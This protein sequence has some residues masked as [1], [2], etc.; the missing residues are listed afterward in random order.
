MVSNYPFPIE[1]RGGSCVPYPFPSCV[2][3]APEPPSRSRDFNVSRGSASAKLGRSPSV[4]PVLLPPS[5]PRPSHSSLLVTHRLSIRPIKL[6]GPC[7]LTHHMCGGYASPPAQKVSS[8][9]GAGFG[10][11]PAGRTT[12]SSLDVDS[13]RQFEPA[14]SRL[15]GSR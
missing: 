1:G 7:E 5:A 13:L 10:D 12:S 2:G 9:S 15:S 3:S 6:D 4:E 11:Y 14:T 8:A